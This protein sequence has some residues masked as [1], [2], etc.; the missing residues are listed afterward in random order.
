MLAG[1]A[2]LL[3][4]FAG[5]ILNTT[6]GWATLLLF[7]KV[8]ASRQMLL[9]VMVFGSLVWVVLVVGV[10]VPTVGTLLLSGVSLP[11]FVDLGW[12]RLGMLIG[13]LVLPA[14]IGGLALLVADRSSRPGG[15]AGVVGILRGYPFAL[16]LA[17][18][19]VV[20]ALVASFR[21]LRSMSRR[22]QDAHVPVV[23]KPGRYED[24]LG[25]LSATLREAGLEHAVRDAGQ[26]ISGPPKLLDLVAGRALGTL[27]PDQLKLLAGPGF[28][29]LVYPSDVAISGSKLCLARARAAISAR[30]VEVPA[31]MTTTAE[32]QSVEDELAKAR[33]DEDLAEI[34]RTL[35]RLTVPYEEWEVLYRQRL[36]VELEWLK[37]RP[38]SPT[39][40]AVPATGETRL[41]ALAARPV[42]FAIA[43]VGLSLIALD[44]VLVLL[45]RSRT[46]Q[47]R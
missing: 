35:S 9:L 3:G 43:G 13:A 34:D 2:S 12:I 10:L 6:L 14:V 28:E 41:R 32:A 5:Q 4:R 36:Q 39:T 21:K 47:S 29:A 25:T 26:L 31:Y 37:G 20:L 18:T 8:P 38:E 1:I 15:F 22:W 27:V 42:D 11:A 7:G 16:V 17:L 40:G 45:G 30:L 33:T 44:L 23:V 46:K 19:L 24:V